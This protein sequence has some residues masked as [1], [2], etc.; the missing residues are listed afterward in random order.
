MEAN[1][2]TAASSLPRTR[3]RRSVPHLDKLSIAPLSSTEYPLDA[4]AYSPVEGGSGIATPSHASYIQGRSAPTT[5]GILSLSQSHSRHRRHQSSKQGYRSDVNSY[6]P[7]ESPNSASGE[8]GSDNASSFTAAELSTTTTNFNIPKAKSSSALLPGSRNRHSILK[9]LQPLTPHPTS[10]HT[11][12]HKNISANP[13]SSIISAEWLHRAGLAIASETRDAKGQ[14][15]LISRASST[16][17]TGLSLPVEYQSDDTSG[18][19]TAAGGLKASKSENTIHNNFSRPSSSLGLA[20]ADDERSLSP[21]LSRAGS[22]TVS[23]RNSRRGSRVEMHSG[24]KTPSDAYY[25]VGDIVALQVGGHANTMGPDFVNGDEE[26]EYATAEVDEEEVAMLARERGFGLGG[27]VDRLVGWTL[28]KVEE[29]ENG[30][31]TEGDAEEDRLQMETVT[32]EDRGE[33]EEET[34]RRRRKAEDADIIESS[35]VMKEHGIHIDAPEEEGDGGWKDAAWLLSVA[36]K[37]LL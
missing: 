7:S 19:P 36:S 2:D 23:V 35:R 34:K 26:D 14:S 21:Y 15:W 12:L 30:S 10:K 17:L 16:S 29:D 25:D 9:G 5:P 18:T 27:W 6:F 28:F 1:N 4:A 37:V 8:E 20:F 33:H 31:E 22:R 32:D 13:S 24:R 11:V 3:S